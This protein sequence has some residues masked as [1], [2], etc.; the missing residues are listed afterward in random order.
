MVCPVAGAVQG[1]QH[2][3]CMP[4]CMRQH[5][6]VLVIRQGTIL[7][8]RDPRASG[9]SQPRPQRACAIRRAGARWGIPPFFVERGPGRGGGGGG[10][11]FK[12]GAPTTARNAL[13]LLRAL[14]LRRAVL[15]EGSPGVGK[16]SLVAALARATGAAP[17]LAP[18]Q[19]QANMAH[20]SVPGVIFFVSC[21][22]QIGVIKPAVSWAAARSRY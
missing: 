20:S 22:K 11:A 2:H 16:T 17:R 15:L 13:R 8:L 21:L 19:P 9:P 1:A 5:Q 3:W 14:Q 10:V 18:Q 6:E 12:F 7:C 4:A